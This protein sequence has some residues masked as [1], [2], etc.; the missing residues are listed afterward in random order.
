M[1][2]DDGSFPNTFVPRS[3]ARPSAVHRGLWLIADTILLLLLGIVLLALN[4]GYAIVSEGFARR[5]QDEHAIVAWVLGHLNPP[6]ALALVVGAFYVLVRVVEGLLGLD[7]KSFRATTTKPL[8]FLFLVGIMELCPWLARKVLP[9]EVARALLGVLLILVGT[10]SAFRFPPKTG[11]DGV[12]MI[13]L[14]VSVEGV[15]SLLW[16]SG[17]LWQGWGARLAKVA[18]L[19]AVAMA[20]RRRRRNKRDNQSDGFAS[21]A[22]ALGEAVERAWSFV[23]TVRARRG[24]P[25]GPADHGQGGARPAPRP[26]SSPPSED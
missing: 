15:A 7:G 25:L 6:W 11:K 26:A 22:Q 14:A 10:S 20:W 12:F 2:D 16:D 17:W 18:V 9:S 3:A 13:G 1:A 8:R 23:L 4:P 21:S 5:W 19:A 24:R